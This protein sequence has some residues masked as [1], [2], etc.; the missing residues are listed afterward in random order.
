MNC[1]ENHEAQQTHGEPQPHQHHSTP[2]VCKRATRR[3]CLIIGGAI[4]A[5][6]LITTT[7]I[8]RADL[9][10]SNQLEDEHAMREAIQYMNDVERQLES[11][12]MDEHEK[13]QHA[14]QMMLEAEPY[15]W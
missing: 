14:I 13:R 6:V 9:E 2:D 7:L 1:N 15:E 3:L 4:L 8:N 10:T 12:L 11:R 5:V